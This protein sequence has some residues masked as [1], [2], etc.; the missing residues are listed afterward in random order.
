M[1][2]VG[3]IREEIGRILPGTQVIEFASQAL[4]RAEARRKAAD[5]ATQALADEQTGRDRLRA[6]KEGSFVLM[7][8]IVIAAAALW[9]GLLALVN[10][11]ERRA[12]VG[13]LRALGWAGS[14]VLLLFVLR[15]AFIGLVGSLLGCGAALALLAG[16]PDGA[17]VVT[18]LAN[19]AVLAAAI[20]GAP[21]LSAAACWIPSLVAL[22]Q[23]PAVV[24]RS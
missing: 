8:L 22:Q 2:A 13:V 7:T 18:M 19:P 17:Q 5:Y 16:R 4:A 24:L 15:A 12:E 6:E 9:V 1:A 23:D 14:R 3:K 21:L 20:V 11:N 10:V